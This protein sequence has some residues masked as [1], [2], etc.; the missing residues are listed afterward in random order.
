M[1]YNSGTVPSL[2]TDGFEPRGCTMTRKPIPPM[3]GFCVSNTPEK[4]IT[5]RTFYLREGNCESAGIF[6][7][8]P[9]LAP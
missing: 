5:F 3:I 9:N 2:L 4:R 8:S 1:I 7:K 6:Q